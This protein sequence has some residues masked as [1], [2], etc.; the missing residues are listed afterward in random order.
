[1]EKLYIILSVL[2][3]S[4]VTYAQEL[5]IQN[6]NFVQCTG[7]FTDSGG[8]AGNY[9]NNENFTITICPQNAGESV[10]LDFTQFATQA[11]DVMEI[12]NAD[13][14]DQFFYFGKF[15]V[16]KHEDS[17]GNYGDNNLNGF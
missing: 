17:P 8:A 11:T 7:T 1:M 4:S 13:N 3:I 15:N 6:G 14:H 9:G 16:T 2:I 10:Q 12:F 5:V